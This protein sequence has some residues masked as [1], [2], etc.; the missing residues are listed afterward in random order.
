MLSGALMKIKKEIGSSLS[1]LITKKDGTGLAGVTVTLSGPGTLRTALT[2]TKGKYSFSGLENVRYLII[3]RCA[4]Y[5]FKPLSTA[6]AI[7]GKNVSGVN[8]AANPGAN[9][10]FAAGGLDNAVIRSD[11][12]L[13][14]WGGNWYGGVGDGTNVMKNMAEQIGNGT[15]WAAVS[16]G[17]LHTA[18]IKSDG[19]LWTWGFNERGQL[20]DGTTQDQHAPVQI[21]TGNNWS[22]ISAGDRHTAALKSD[23]T[24]WA[25]GANEYGQLGDGTT[26]DKHT[27]LQ[28]GAAADWI[29]V[30]A[31]PYH[32]MALKRNGTLWTWGIN[33]DGQLGDG[34]TQNRLAPAQVGS[35]TDWVVVRAGFGHT[36]ALKSDGTLW[37]WGFNPHGNLGD[38]TTM[39]MRLSPGQVGSDRD[40]VAIAAGWFFTVALKTNG[41]LWACGWNGRGELGDGTTTSKLVLTQVGTD[42]N[43]VSVA[44]GQD[45]TLALKA[46]GTF[47]A[48]GGN[49][50]G[51]LGDGTTTD[52]AV[53]TLVVAGATVVDQSNRMSSGW[54][55]LAMSWD[56]AQTFEPGLPVLAGVDIDLKTLNPQL[57]DVTIGVEV[58]DQNHGLLAKAS[59]TVHAGSTDPGLVHFDFTPVVAVT[60]GTAYTLHVPGSK[61]T[62]GWKYSGN[63]HYPDGFGSF[64]NAHGTNTPP[65]QDFLFQTWGWSH[66]PFSYYR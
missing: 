25:W 50:W 1:G 37:A 24:L 53:P 14:C 44:A 65:G 16:V 30:T 11:G 35:D 17:A 41:T 19:T 21:G 10:L 66:T 55:V 27:P 20:G 7:A 38:G 39:S 18:A 46:N 40:W 51:T 26:V 45:H 6:T 63:D 22:A 36:V 57:G 59:Q 34:T 12:S 15:D 62:F 13:W 2:D 56:I 8:F 23:G 3:P 31:G 33:N 9:C 43:W 47:W 4:N 32:T 5:E 52:R 29:A 60:T 28:I 49:G 48:W 64:S 58:L 61:D 54:G 42:T